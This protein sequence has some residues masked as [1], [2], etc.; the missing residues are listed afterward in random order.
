MKIRSIALVAT[1]AAVAAWPSLVS[2]ESASQDRQTITPAFRDAIPNIPGKS[3]VAIVVSY[4]P[5]GA[6]RA[7]YH[8]RSSFVKGYV[9]SG[10]IRS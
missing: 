4:P 8:P 5:G 10:S 1:L 9:L 2:A 3:L 6:T 7:H